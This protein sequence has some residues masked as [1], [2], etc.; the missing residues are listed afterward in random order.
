M[1]YL[2]VILI[3]TIVFALA[4]AALIFGAV[5]LARKLAGNLMLQIA[6]SIFI[7]LTQGG[8]IF[9]LLGSLKI[10]QLPWAIAAAM[11][12]GIITAYLAKRL[13]DQPSEPALIFDGNTTYAHRLF[14]LVYCL[15]GGLY[16]YR[17]VYITGTDATLY[18]LYYPAMWISEGGIEAIT[19]L[20]LP[21]EYFPYCGEC[22]YGWLMLTGE[23]VPFYTLLQPLA[24]AMAL[25]A[26]AG[27]WQQYKIPRL[28]TAGAVIWI[29]SVGIIFEN[30]SIC[31][32]DTLCGAFLSL[33]IIFLL[34]LTFRN[35]DMNPAQRRFFAA[36][37]GIAMGFCAAIKYSGLVLAPILTLALTVWSCVKLY[38]RQELKKILKYHLLLLTS[39]IFSAGIFYL[40]NLLKTGNLFYPVK[41]PFIFSNG[42]DFE[43]PPVELNQLWSFFVNESS[44]S[45]NGVQAVFFLS[46]LLL[47]LLYGILNRKNGSEQDSVL[48]EII[49]TLAILLIIAEAFMISIY[50]AMTQARSGIPFLMAVSLLTAPLL[51]WLLHRIINTPRRETV[52]ALAAFMICYLLTNWNYPRRFQLAVIILT[53]MIV[54]LPMLKTRRQF[55]ITVISTITLSLM[56]FY[57]C[58]FLRR[59]AV[60]ELADKFYDPETAAAIKFINYFHAENNFMPLR[61]ASAGCYFNYN[62][63]LDMPGN[64]VKCVPVNKAGTT[65][66][67]EVKNLEELRGDAYVDYRLWLERLRKGGFSLL[68]VDLSS[69]QDFPF[70][71][72]LELK[73]AQA[74]SEVFI[75]VITGKN[76][77]LFLIKKQ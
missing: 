56:L 53:I 61:I 63:M 35:A 57:F 17:S 26:A 49:P 36:A 16:L 46:I 10:L 24:L 39:A 5:Q 37:A 21:H 43:R 3:G 64:Q 59:N 74:H 38:Q 42:I 65:H 22:M 28:F 73:W 27:F 40:A 20:G 71:R 54:L 32:S 6:L 72:D 62:L 29:A 7:V 70:N 30:A 31:Y 77:H 4:N 50:P 51:H 13:P 60:N 11:L 23:D 44:W 68:L 8:L 55:K 34:Q 69:Y 67:H 58:W 45:L 1:D 9:L 76:V 33:G 18:H 12:C 19:L 47:A 2:A 48:K 15:A 25:C 75:P 41:I 66:P 52:Y 14:G